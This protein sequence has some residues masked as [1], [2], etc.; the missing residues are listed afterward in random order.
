MNVNFSGNV[1]AQAAP[2]ETVTVTITFPD[3]KT[4]DTQ[5]ATTQADGTFAT[6]AKSYMIAGTYTWVA[7]IAADSEYKAKSVTGSFTVTLVDRILT[8]QVNAT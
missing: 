5:T 6:Q 7:N 4:T 8:V 3:G 1:S 2:G